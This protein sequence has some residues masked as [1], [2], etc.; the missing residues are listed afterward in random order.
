MEVAPQELAQL[1]KLAGVGAGPEP[2]IMS[3]PEVMSE[4]DMPGSE[5]EPEISVMAIPSDDGAPVGGGCGA[6]SQNMITNMILVEKC[7]V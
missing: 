2:D 7:V 1:L 6:P 3:G 4:P 5:I